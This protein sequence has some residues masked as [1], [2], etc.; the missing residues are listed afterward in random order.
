MF[1]KRNDSIIY[2]Y[3]IRACSNRAFDC[4][5]KRRSAL[6]FIVGERRA[7]RRADGLKIA[8]DFR[9]LFGK[10]RS[11]PRG[12][13]YLPP[14]IVKLNNIYI[15]RGKNKKKPKNIA[16]ATRVLD[17]RRSFRSLSGG[18]LRTRWISACASE[19]KKKTIITI[20]TSVPIRK[21]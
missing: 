10:I 13:R 1:I 11:R 16:S 5:V 19:N 6:L 7:A 20:T 18:P 14:K 15:T 9:K 2:Y 12:V 3:K 4:V 8:A 21:K 17:T